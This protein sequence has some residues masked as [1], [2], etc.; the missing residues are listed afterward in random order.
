[1]KNK[2]RHE[3]DLELENIYR[4][5]GGY[6]THVITVTKLPTGAHEVQ[7]N[8]EEL[9]AKLQYISMAYDQDMRLRSN[10]Q[11]QI[12]GLLIVSR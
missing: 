7:V 8:T 5:G 12:M 4:E 11:I 1:V 10:P 6:L 9:P 2:T 3:L